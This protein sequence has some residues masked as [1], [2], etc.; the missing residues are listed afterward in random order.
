MIVLLLIGFMAACIVLPIEVQLWREDERW[1]NYFRNWGEEIRLLE[2][3]GRDRAFR[4][5]VTRYL[6]RIDK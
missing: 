6:Q 3:L 1:R 4:P 2:Y 5:T